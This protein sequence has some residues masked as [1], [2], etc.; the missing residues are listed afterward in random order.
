MAYQL[1]VINPVEDL[2]LTDRQNYRMRAIEAGIERALAKKIAPSRDELVVR[3]AQNIADFATTVDQWNTPVLA[4]A[5]VSVFG[6]AA[7]PVLAVT[8]VAVFY[9]VTVT[10]APIPVAA[11]SFRE[12]AAAGTTK[13]IFDLEQLD[14]Y[15]VPSGYFS[16]PVTYDPQN[17][18]NVVVLPR[19][20]T[21]LLCRVI[22]GCYIIEPA[23]AT[24]S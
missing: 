18:L 17:V 16:E 12:G 6:T 20:A 11:L 8:K 24:I 3:H 21:G 9:K 23:G 7:A 1:K 10:T 2:T 22:M 4:A 13:A 5:L 19:I 15:L 14:G